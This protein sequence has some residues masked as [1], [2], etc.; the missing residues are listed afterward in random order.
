M[1]NLKQKTLS[2]ATTTRAASASAKLAAM[3]AT[4][5][6]PDESGGTHTDSGNKADPI[7]KNDLEA[8]LNT[9]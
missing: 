5:A 9:T 6:E 1:S 2:M 7:S 4:T 3:F 8:L